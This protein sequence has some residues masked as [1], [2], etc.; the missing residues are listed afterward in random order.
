MEAAKAQ[1]AAEAAKAQADEEARIVQ[2][3]R[4]LLRRLKK[5][6]LMRTASGIRGDGVAQRAIAERQW[7]V[8]RPR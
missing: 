7:A 6:R 2:R 5:R 3:P 8:P 1:A 4:L